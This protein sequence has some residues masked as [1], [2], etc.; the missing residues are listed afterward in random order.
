MVKANRIRAASQLNSAQSMMLRSSVQE[1][2]VS[3]TSLL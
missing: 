1:P 2:V 3:S